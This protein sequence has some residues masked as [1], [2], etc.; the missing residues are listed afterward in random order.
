M[1]INNL[2][3]KIAKQFDEADNIVIKADTKFRDLEGW[4]SLIALSIIAMVDEEYNVKIKGDE[5]REAQTI[6]DLFN[7]IQ[8]KIK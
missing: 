7:I 6:E 4:S 8:S 2:I 1:Q 3:V 5:I